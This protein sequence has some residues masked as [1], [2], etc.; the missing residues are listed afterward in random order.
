MSF[1][2]FAPN[3]HHGDRMSFRPAIVVL[4]VL[5]IA[6][7][8]LTPIAGATDVP[9]TATPNSGNEAASASSPA[10]VEAPITSTA[11]PP[12][13]S[14]ETVDLAPLPAAAPPIDLTAQHDDLWDRIR[15]GFAMQNLDSPLVK[16]HQNWYENQPEYL[17]RVVERS[18]RYMHHIIDELEKRGMPTELALL[19]IVE[20]SY[21]PLAISTARASGLW[22][23]IPSTGRNYKL[24]QTW[25]VDERRDVLASTDAALEY[26]QYIYEMHGDWQLALA[27]YNW[28]EGA[29][30]RAIAK[31]RAKKLPTD[32]ASLKMPKETQN[33]VPKLQALKNLLL[34]RERWAALEIPSLP[35]KP[36][37]GTVA[38]PADM[39]VKM[40]ARFAEMPLDEF[41]ALNPAHNRPV[42]KGDLPII[43]PADKVETFLSNYAQ[44]EDPLVN[45]HTYTFQKTDNLEKLAARVGLTVA[46]LKAINGVTGRKAKVVPGQAL[47]LPSQELVDDDEP[48]D[49]FA[50]P[51]APEKSV[52]CYKRGKKKI[53]RTVYHRPAKPMMLVADKSVP[54]R[55]PATTQQ[56]KPAPAAKLAT[57]GRSG[58]EKLTRYTVKSGDTIDGI[59]RK[60]KVTRQAIGRHNELKDIIKPG[61]ILLIPG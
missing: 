31:N 11:A 35:N 12:P 53:C 33:Y 40:A 22:Q 8:T 20:S 55:A 13:A 56:K 34:D 45:W 17:R 51:A 15:N 23:F 57:P 9:P 48:L 14:L 59:A 50:P 46:Q 25:W 58:S 10:S 6:L 32:Y 49:T 60:H 2:G 4:L 54:K 7:A 28:G 19:P 61:Q 18:R 5:P 42:I 44:N 30:S 1:R 24:D 16:R 26:L 27:S 52:R 47:L 41:R 36:F 43:L 3:L 37:F 38:K 21:N 29:V 39:D